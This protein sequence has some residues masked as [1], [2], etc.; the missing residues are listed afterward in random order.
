MTRLQQLILDDFQGGLN[1]R[2][3]Q[4]HLDGTESP[5]LCNMLVDPRGG[6]YTRP[7]WRRWQG[8]ADFAT[9]DTWDPRAAEAHVHL[10]DTKSVFVTNDGDIWHSHSGDAG[11]FSKLQVA[12]VDIPCTGSPH[13]A[14]FGSWGDSVYIACGRAS[15]SHRHDRDGT[16]TALTAPS[17]SDPGEGAT[18]VGGWNNDYT[19]PVGGYAPQAEFCEPHAGYMFYANINEDAGSGATDYPT[20]IRWSHPGGQ[21][22]DFAYGDYIDIDAGGGKITGLMSFQDQLLIFKRDTLW[23][24][25]GYDNDSWQLIK[26]SRHIGAPSSA[27]I[28]RSETAAYFFSTSG[29]NGIYGY[30]DGGPV[31]VSGQIR[32]AVEAVT[33]DDDVWLGWAGQKLFCN[34]PVVDLAA[35]S[36]ETTTYVLDLTVGNGAWVRH[37]MAAASLGPMVEGTDVIDALPL[38]VVRSSDDNHQTIMELDALDDAVD[39][40]DTVPTDEPFIAHYSTGWNFAGHP[41]RLKSWRRPRHVVRRPNAD[42]NILVEGRRNYVEQSDRVHLMT[43]DSD[44]LP[45]WRGSMVSAPSEALKPFTDLD[46][47]SNVATVT[48]AAH[49]Y[50]VGEQV[51]IHDT[52]NTDIDGAS[53]VIATVPDVN[54][55][56][57]AVTTADVL[58]LTGSVGEVSSDDAGVASP[59]GDGFN[60]DDGTL[61]SAATEGSALVRSVDSAPQGGGFGKARALKLRYSSTDGVPWGIDA[62]ILKYID[63]RLTT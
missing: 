30:A 29:R 8:A 17:G 46:V 40:L 3:N 18:G 45:Y 6:F 47:A 56:T 7:G 35:S 36:D 50:S 20:R 49:G 43:I 14:D 51:E 25:Y 15:T 62:V 23:A 26:V 2:A 48:M 57:F 59:G 5:D 42:V 58:N 61:W 16:N 32:P 9:G 1:L 19:N 37:R 22:E 13:L 28:T 4:F 52:G 53:H 44:G 41:D 34:L 27:A 54:T 11:V 38:S 24:L 12:A 60:W 55:F 33:S 39:R 31:E 10:D 63:R 21:P